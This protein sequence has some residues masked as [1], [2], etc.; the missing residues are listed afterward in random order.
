[1][2]GIYLQKFARR[3]S[4]NLAPHIRSH[5]KNVYASFALSS[6]CAS[7]GVYLHMF[8]TVI[9]AGF[10]TF[11]GAIGTLLA[12]MATPYDGGKNQKQRLELLGVFAF[13]SGINLG[14]I[15]QMS[16]MV[17][18]TLILQALLGTSIIF[19]C[20]SLA[21]FYAPRSQYLYL[22]GILMSCLSIII[23]LSIMNV[24]LKSTLIYQANIYIGLFTMCG[25][26]IFDTQSIIE[27]AN[28]GEKDYV[29]HSLYLFI[30]CIGI[31]KRILIILTDREATKR[32][33]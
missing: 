4:A 33:K 29:M 16:I 8:N 27:K 1:M 5:L 28:R 15:L 31:F 2:E 18:P 30:D 21:A 10:F 14:P 11:L 24:F 25:L 13:F 6:L 19:F 22:G 17:D 23:C 7:V 9:G 26:V 3:I 32:K 20:F 12:L